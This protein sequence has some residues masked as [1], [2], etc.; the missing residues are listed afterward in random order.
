VS[1]RLNQIRRSAASPDVRTAA[2]GIASVL[3]NSASNAMM[4]LIALRGLGP[5]DAR[6]L[7]VAYGLLTFLVVVVKALFAEP[8]ALVIDQFGAGRSV[9]ARFLAAGVAFAVLGILLGGQFSVAWGSPASALALCAVPVCAV[10]GRRMLLLSR[11]AAQR[12]LLVDITWIVAQ[13]VAI[14]LLGG[15]GSPTASIVAWG[16]G[17]LIGFAV[18]GHLTDL[19]PSFRGHGLSIGHVRLGRWVT[20]ETLSLASVLAFVPLLAGRRDASIPTEIRL[21]LTAFSPYQVVAVGF[22][23]ATLKRLREMATRGRHRLLGAVIAAF[24]AMLVA[25]CWLTTLVLRYSPVT[26][27]HRLGGQPLEAAVSLAGSYAAYLTVAS[28]SFALALWCRANALQRNVAHIRIAHSAVALLLCAVA[29]ISRIETLFMAA[30]GLE[31]CV[32]LA[33]ALLIGRSIAASKRLEARVAESEKQR[34][35]V[36]VIS[37]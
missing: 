13:T 36:G 4:L 17:A 31:A 23:A 25:V 9:L 27:W 30:A 5:L 11:G 22:Q 28:V 20:A 15:L 37:L 35:S 2:A 19:L 8:L 21:L 33:L 10:E 12:S 7:T 26:L 6:S 14:A 32:G 1:R 29:H 24:A 18:S 3:V 16:A 34:P